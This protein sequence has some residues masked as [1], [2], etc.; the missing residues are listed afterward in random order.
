MKPTAHIDHLLHD[1]LDGSLPPE[2]QERL[3]AHL[4][5]CPGVVA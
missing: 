5:T 2:E 1:Y 4:R 3:E